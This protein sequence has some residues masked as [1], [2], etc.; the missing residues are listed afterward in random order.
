MTFS[1]DVNPFTLY[2]K[3]IHSRD[4]LLERLRSK[5]FYI[6]ALAG[7]FAFMGSVF[8]FIVAL[9]SNTL[10]HKEGYLPAI[11]DGTR[12]GYYLVMLILGWFFPK[13]RFMG[14]WSVPL[15]FA[16]SVT[17]GYVAAGLPDR[18]Y[19]RYHLADSLKQNQ[20]K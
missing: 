12:T 4:M 10:K 11:A 13:V 20:F 2:P 8:N 1:K 17:E 9:C 18:I 19:N 15:V 16:I 5:T 6:L 14:A 3:D 7:I